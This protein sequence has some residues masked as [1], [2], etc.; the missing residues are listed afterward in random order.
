MQGGSEMAGYPVPDLTCICFVFLCFW[1]LLLFWRPLSALFP[2]VTVRFHASNELLICL[3]GCG[4]R[5][6]Q[7]TF[8]PFWLCAVRVRIHSIGQ[9]IRSAMNPKS[10]LHCWWLFCIVIC[11]HKMQARCVC[12]LIGCLCSTWAPWD[13]ACHCFD[14]VCRTDHQCLSALTKPVENF[15]FPRWD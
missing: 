4:I 15:S 2:F 7:M 14:S 1:L 10:H 5:W 3:C 11:W 12:S 8:R 6:L 9:P 13:L